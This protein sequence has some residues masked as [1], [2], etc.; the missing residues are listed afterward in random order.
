MASLCISWPWQA[1]IISFNVPNSSFILERRRRS[2]KLC[3]VLRAILRPAALVALGFFLAVEA[4]A[5]GDVWAEAF[6]FSLGL[7]GDFEVAA[8]FGFI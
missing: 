5:S 8:D 3:A 6:P 7:A 4:F 2:I 1:G